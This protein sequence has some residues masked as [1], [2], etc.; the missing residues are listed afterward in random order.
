MK[1]EYPIRLA[2]Q[3]LGD[4]VG[5]AMGLLSKEKEEIKNNFFRVWDIVEILKNHSNTSWEDVGEFLGHYDF[6]TELTLFKVDTYHRIHNVI[7]CEV[8]RQLID[9]L[10]IF[11]LTGENG[12]KDTKSKVL[13][14]YWLKEEIYNFKPLIELNLE[15]FKSSLNYLDIEKEKPNDPR[16][17]DYKFYLFKQPL[18]NAT[19]C[20]CIVAEQNPSEVADVDKFC[21]AQKL[22]YSAIKSGD[23]VEVDHYINTDCLRIYL[24][25]SNIIIKGF[26]DDVKQ[27]SENEKHSLKNKIKELEKIIKENN[28]Q[29]N[30]LKNVNPKLGNDLLDQVFDDTREESYAPD[31]A[32]AIKL[33]ESIYITNPKDDSHTNK[34]NNWLKQN[35]NYDV[36][37]QN[38]SASKIREITSPLKSWSLQRDR[39]FKR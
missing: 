16:K 7:T 23:L 31:L 26:N 27:L 19:D 28:N 36:R 4:A 21:M 14:Y 39:K 6:A 38:S 18:L 35:T 34:A 3:F 33:W 12:L 20:A 13:S 25:D 32:L 22:I 11:W 1:V 5:G 30:I 29:I 24:F 9:D 8:V 17:K 2:Y 10:Q 15:N 37:K